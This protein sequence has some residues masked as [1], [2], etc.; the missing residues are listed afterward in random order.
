MRR[1]RNGRVG[2]PIQNVT[3]RRRKFKFGR[4]GFPP[5][6]PQN[7]VSV[8]LSTASKTSS[9]TDLPSSPRPLA[10][11]I[12]QAPSALSVDS[13]LTKSCGQPLWKFAFRNWFIT[14]IFYRMNKR[15]SCV[16]SLTNSNNRYL[17]AVSSS[18]RGWEKKRT[19]QTETDKC[20]NNVVLLMGRF[21]FCLRLKQNTFLLPF[22]RCCSRRHRLDEMPSIPCRF[23]I[24]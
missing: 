13:F 21:F 12:T 22:F 17:W 9:S 1:R 8:E 24:S 23:P 20:Q 15:V 18:S 3:P 4:I 16:I 11:Q 7:A 10:P 14:F 6:P 19:D 5:L 2:L